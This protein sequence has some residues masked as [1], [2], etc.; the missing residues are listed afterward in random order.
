ML[1]GKILTLVFTFFLSVGPVIAQNNADLITLSLKNKTIEQALEII[2]KQNNYTFVLKTPGIDTKKT[3]SIEAQQQAVKAILNTLFKG[4]DVTFDINGKTVRISKTNQ[5]AT[6][7]QSNPTTQRIVTGQ[8]T[9]TSGEPMS[10]VNVVIKGTTTGVTTDAEGRYNIQVNSPNQILQFS[11]IGFI[12]SEKKVGEN[13]TIH[14]VLDE[15]VKN[16]EEVV[17]MGYSVQKKKDVTGSVSTV[18]AKD[19]E[20]I[21]ADRKSVV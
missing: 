14:I 6:E 5:S 2:N 3:I 7:S 9:D 21:P 20:N 16:L 1:F 13:K 4:Q 18:L 12:Q 17:V 8:I 15:D 11:F 10:G 19:I